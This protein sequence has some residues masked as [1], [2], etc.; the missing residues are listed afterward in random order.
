[1]K[2]FYIL[3]IDHSQFSDLTVFWGPEDH[4]YTTDLKKAGKYSEE[5]LE[6]NKY[7]YNNGTT[8]IAIPCEEVEK[9]IQNVVS[10]DLIPSFFTYLR[11]AEAAANKHV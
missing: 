10:S 5:Q 9:H 3:S 7:M 2:T 8:A 1:M 11:Q 4:G 6:A